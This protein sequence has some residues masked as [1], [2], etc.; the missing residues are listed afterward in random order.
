[1]SKIG[2]KQIQIPE[3]VQVVQEKYTLV[4]KGPK[5][6]LTC[7]T[8]GYVDI[9]IENNEIWL[10]PK[11][12]NDTTQYQGLYRTLIN[13]IVTGVSKG[14]EKKLEFSGIGYKASVQN[15][16]LVLN[17][18]YSH[19]VIVKKVEG[20]DFAVNDNVITVIGI[21]KSLVGDIAAKIRAVRPPDVYRPKG[22]KYQNEYIV[23][24][25]VKSMK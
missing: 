23:R 3:G 10:S 15:G 7:D 22:I 2:K 17:V 14:F 1:M 18:G 21:D 4:A 6:E 25:E 20:I 8:K 9:K 13:N 16:D 24:K 11:R 19:P 5:G 12:K